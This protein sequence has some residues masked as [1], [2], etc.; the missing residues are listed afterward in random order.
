MTPNPKPKLQ[1][2]SRAIDPLKFHE[3]PS[4]NSRSVEFHK[5]RVDLKFNSFSPARWLQTENVFAFSASHHD[6]WPVNRQKKGGNLKI[7]AIQQPVAIDHQSRS[8]ESDQ[9]ILSGP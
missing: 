5:S 2:N 8:N 6:Q 9:S 1:I 7:S 4:K 3:N